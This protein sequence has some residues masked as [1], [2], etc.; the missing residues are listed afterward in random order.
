MFG[1][2]FGHIL[3]IFG[4][5]FGHVLDML[6]TSLGHVRDVFWSSLGHVRD[7]FGTCLNMTKVVDNGSRASYE[8]NIKNTSHTRPRDIEIYYI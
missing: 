8:L 5:C 2:C 3:D 1:S 6:G 4:A 7:M